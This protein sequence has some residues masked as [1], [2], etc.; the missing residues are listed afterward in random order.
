MPGCRSAR[1]SPSSV[2]RQGRARSAEVRLD[3]I[4]AVRGLPEQG[5]TEGGVPEHEDCHHCDVGGKDAPRRTARID[6]Y[7]ERGEARRP[8]DAAARTT[9][10]RGERAPAPPLTGGG[11]ELSYRYIFR[12]IG[13]I[14]SGSA[15]SRP[16]PLRRHW[17][18]CAVANGCSTPRKVPAQQGEGLCFGNMDAAMVQVR[19]GR[20]GEA[21]MDS[22]GGRRI[23]GA[24]GSE[25]RLPAPS[26]AVCA[27]SSSTRS[28]SDLVTAMK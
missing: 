4:A 22:E 8:E 25:G 18:A 9:W 15:C 28:P 26:A 2:S 14:G 13:R 20:S 12:T 17:P 16:T 24:V 11:R 23:G 10:R 5:S 21:G 6:P 3:L 1:R 27:T 19:E 7:R